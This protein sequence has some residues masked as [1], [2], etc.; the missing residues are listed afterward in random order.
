MCY[1]LTTNF[2]ESYFRETLLRV[3][4][5][6]QLGGFQDCEYLQR[7]LAKEF[8]QMESR[9]DIFPPFAFVYLDQM[10]AKQYY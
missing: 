6:V 2:A 4:E 3:R 9:Y 1:E 7:T 5:L 8:Q 10:I